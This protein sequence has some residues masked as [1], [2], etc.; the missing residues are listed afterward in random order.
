LPFGIE[1][2]PLVEAVGDD[3][4]ALAP[5]PRVAERRLRREI[6]RSRVEGRILQLVVLR[7]WSSGDQSERGCGP[8]GAQQL[9]PAIDDV[10]VTRRRRSGTKAKLHRCR[11][12]TKAEFEAGL[13]NDQTIDGKYPVANRHYKKRIDFG[14]A[15]FRISRQL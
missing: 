11:L 10:P 14:F 13:A 2:L 3:E 7:P 4:A 9:T 5:F 1:L 6:L 12:F 8:L 15:D